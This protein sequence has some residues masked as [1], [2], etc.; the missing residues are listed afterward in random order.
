MD[1]GK[2]TIIRLT[3]DFQIENFDCDD[4][5]LNDFFL[6]NSKKFSD[7]LLAV[8]YI[9]QS[10]GNTIAFFSI[11]NDKISIKEIKSLDD[12][13]DFQSS[14]FPKEKSL[15]SFP[16]V[17]IG[18]LGVNKTYQKKGVGKITVDYLINSFITS[19]KTGC[20]FITVDAYQQSL[21][22]YEK[23]GF[24]YLTKKDQNKDTRLMYLDLHPYYPNN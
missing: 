17:K 13:K 20:R 9:I 5:D 7:Q 11:F 23:T 21:T 3:Q 22:F 4:D 6:N 2:L 16:A 18:R 12:W 10:D 8:T 24:D 15:T 19:N 1:L 14:H